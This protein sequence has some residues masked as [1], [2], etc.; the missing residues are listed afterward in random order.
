MTGADHDAHLDSWCVVPL[1]DGIRILFGYALAHEETDGL[2][3]MSGS[4]LLEHDLAAGRAV[5]RS[6]RHYLLG[7]RFEAVDVGAEGAEAR[8]A[9]VLLIGLGYEGMADLHEVD[10]RW[11][12]ACKAARHLGIEPP[13]RTE[14]ATRDFVDRHAEAYF[15]V[16]RR[17]RRSAP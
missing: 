5:T 12:M 4:E 7:R 11:L 15:A 1:T 2:A 14:A 10:L 3:W 13:S 8:L 6:G 17:G 16:R 9:F